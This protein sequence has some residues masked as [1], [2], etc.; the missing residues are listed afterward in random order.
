MYFV[1]SGLDISMK[2]MKTH[3]KSSL[4]KSNAID[5][6]QKISGIKVYM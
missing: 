1:I 4:R 6:K 2:R 3:P 5:M